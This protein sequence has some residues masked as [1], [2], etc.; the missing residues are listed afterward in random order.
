LR[1]LRLAFTPATAFYAALL[2]TI[3]TWSMTA[4]MEGFL[5]LER[6]IDA[7][8]DWYAYA[9][10]FGRR[11]REGQIC[12]MSQGMRDKLVERARE[13][14]KDSP[15]ASILSISQ[16]DQGY[17]CECPLCEAIDK[18][19]G[20]QSGS[21]ISMINY[22]A[23][24]LGREFPNVSFDTLAY[25]FTRKPPKFIRPAPNVIVRLCSIECSF[26]APLEDVS[27]KSFADDIIGW[28]KICKRL[29]VWDYTTAFEN[30]VLPHPNYFVLGPNVRFFHKNNVKGLFEQGN[31]VSNGG[32]MAELRA[33]VLAQLLWNPYQDD[34]KLIDEF[35]VGYYGKAAAP[36]IREYMEHMAAAAKGFHMGCFT[37]PRNNPP[38][39][40]F[41]VLSKAEQMW[42]KAE[43]AAKGDADQ[44][45]RVKQGHLAV[46]YAFLACWSQLRRECLGA[47]EK[48]PLPLS[49]KAIAEEWLAEATNP[50]P[51]GWT[52][53]TLSNERGQTPQAF[54]ATVS[55][56]VSDPIG[57]IALGTG[58]ASLLG[59][60]MTDPADAVV[61]RGSYAGDEPEAKL[62]P[63][64]STWVDMKCF[65]ANP[66][67]E[68]AH[69]R[70]PYQSWQDSPAV[71]IFL[72]KP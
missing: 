58:T 52:P 6:F 20:S 71:A 66:P 46:R 26:S 3:Q 64:K 36:I 65:P 63:L 45:W 61:D 17:P 23:G 60:D 44:L 14:L 62:R 28:G 11:I 47:G 29:Y 2:D 4:R 13:W 68:Q 12:N 10:E 41:E 49:R 48:W 53:M 34:S 15:T 32:E 37:Q 72:N 70:H 55:T 42:Q 67:G 56:D 8:P 40:K 38:Y 22:V 5:Q 50:G 31:Y 9:K 35:L 54:F 19:E 1:M 7:H 25:Y 16:M 39:L 51:E 27:N 57:T 33:W 59:G 69:Q 30:F 24:K 21:T 43:A 18:R